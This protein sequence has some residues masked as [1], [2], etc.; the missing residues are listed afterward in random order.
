MYQM[1]LTGQVKEGLR[2]NYQIMEVIGNLKKSIF[3]FF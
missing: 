3:F 2:T 1:M